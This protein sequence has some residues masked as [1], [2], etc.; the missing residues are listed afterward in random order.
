M[1]TWGVGIRSDDLVADVIDTFDDCLKRGGSVSAAS[2]A[3]QGKF[4]EV[5]SDPDERP[6]FWIALAESQQRY[7]PVEPRVLQQVR[8]D[9]S[10][11]RGLSRWREIPS[12]VEK[13]KAVLARFLGKIESP[14]TRPRRLPKLI[15]RRPKFQTGDCLST[16]LDSGQY[17]AALV[18]G[19]DESEPEYGVNL[20]G[21][22][23]YMSASQPDLQVFTGRRWR[24]VARQPYDGGVDIAWY[25]HVG[26]RRVADRLSVVAKT[27]VLPGDPK[28]SDIY[29]GFGNLL[30]IA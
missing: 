21:R 6:L 11:G 23:D 5:L 20:I 29:T 13:R 12:D 10:H 4:V 1:G 26:F 25:G 2:T 15:I 22:L 14:N 19:A 28:A 3:V 30:G 24:R 18:L 17:G 16:L 8:D 7:G 9:I 27:T